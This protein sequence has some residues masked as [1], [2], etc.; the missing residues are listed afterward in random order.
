VRE[1]HKEKR[2]VAQ[3]QQEKAAAFKC[4]NQHRRA[5]HNPQALVAA[6]KSLPSPV[7][8][9]KEPDLLQLVW[10][11]RMQVSLLAD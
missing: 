9:L 1:W 5:Y 8:R 7:A 11:W 10:E 4:L 3:R 2:A 6:L